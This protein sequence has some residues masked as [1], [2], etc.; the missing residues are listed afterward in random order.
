MEEEV[1]LGID[2][3]KQEGFAVLKGRHVGLITNHT[4][5]DANGKPTVDLI[6]SQSEIDLKA[7]FGPEHG[8]RGEV[9]APVADGK[10]AQTGLPVYSLYGE[11]TQPTDNQLAGLDTLV[12]D[13]QDIGVRYYTYFSTLGLCLEAAAKHGL[14]FVVLD[15]PNPLGGVRIEGPVAD[16]DSLSFVA[17][18]TVPIRHGLTMGEMARLLNAEKGLNADLHVVSVQGWTRN[19]LWDETGLTWTNP[20][21]NMRSLIAALLYPGIGVM[22]FTNL[23]VGRGTDTPFEVIGAPWLKERKLAA[24]LNA[25]GL[26]GVRFVPIRYTPRSSVFAGESCGGVNILVT[27]WRRFEPVLTGVKIAETLHRIF[28]NDWKPERYNRLLVNKKAYEALMTGASAEKLVNSWHAELEKFAARR[29][30][31]LLY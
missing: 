28:P 16:A 13:I 6:H 23:S 31:Y 1:V 11:R 9:D 22:E 29:R 27:D 20:S 12:Y 18:H 7:L 25:S 24:A 3:L 8:I 26:P 4:G 14:R 2:R 15:R 17:Y 10:D 19:Q 5:L 21:P 30:P